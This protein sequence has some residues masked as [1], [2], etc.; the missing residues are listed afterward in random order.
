MNGF[1]IKY[2]GGIGRVTGSCTLVEHS[3]TKFLVDCGMV[4]GEAHADFEN[5]QPFQF[6]PSEIK[7]IILTHAHL[8]HCGLIPRLADEG[9]TGKIYC[10]DATRKL[11][12][13]ILRDSAKIS[14]LYNNATC[15]LYTSPSPRDRQKSRMP[16]SA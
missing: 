9:F 3:Q 13:E 11:T 14:R 4:Q 16:S 5:T 7:F 1:K 6:K 12:I 8:D 15:L 10:T 2:L